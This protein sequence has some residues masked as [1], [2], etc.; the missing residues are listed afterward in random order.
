MAPPRTAQATPN[1][2]TRQA[3]HPCA[4]QEASGH[5]EENR[6]AGRCDRPHQSRQQHAVLTGEKSLLRGT[7]PGQNHC[8][9]ANAGGDNSQQRAGRPGHS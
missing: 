3:D 2:D 6:K 4:E 1:Q 7:A 9:D 5:I 8:P